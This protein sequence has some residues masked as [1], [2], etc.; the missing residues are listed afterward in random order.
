MQQKDYLN[1]IKVKLFSWKFNW[2]NLYDIYAAG[3]ILVSK[4]KDKMEK[5]DI[6]RC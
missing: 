1:N 5:G 4:T 2:N 3:E 6:D